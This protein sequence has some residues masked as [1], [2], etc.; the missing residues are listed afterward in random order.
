MADTTM[1]FAFGDAYQA[2]FKE[3]KLSRP[4]TY[5]PEDRDEQFYQRMAEWV[6]G[7]YCTPGNT[8]FR[9]GG[10]LGEGRTIAELRAYARGDQPVD[11]YKKQVDFRSDKGNR[12]ELENISWD[13]TR[14]FN[15]F[16]SIAVAQLNAARYRPG[17][18]AV[19]TAAGEA[20]Q[21]QYQADRLASD[22]RS[23]ALFQQVG[24]MPQGVNPAIAAMDTADVDAFNTLGGYTLFPEVLMTDALQAA[25]DMSGWDNLSEAI[26]EDLFD[27]GVA[28]ALAYRTP[29]SN[30]YL[31]RYTDLAGL[32]LPISTYKDFRD[33]QYRAIVERKSLASLRIESDL[34]EEMMEKIAKSYAG[35][36]NNPQWNNDWSGTNRPGR[37]QFSALRSAR[38]DDF[39]IDVMTLYFVALDAEK[40]VTGTRRDGTAVFDRVRSDAKLGGGD[41]KTGKTFE[42]IPVQ[43]VYRCRWVVGTN[44]VF[45]CGKDDTVVRDGEKGSKEVVLPLMVYALNEPSFVERCIP[46]IDDIEISTRKKRLSM[47]M[48]PPGPGFSID[49]AL[50]EESVTI[51]TDTYNVRDLVGIYFNTGILYHRSMN[52]FQT[53][54]DGGSNRPPITPLGSQKLMELQTFIT[55]LQTNLQI[56]RETLGT[57]EVASGTANTNGLLNGVANQMQQTANAALSPLLSA[58]RDFYLNAEKVLALKYQSGVAFG[59]IDLRFVPG[60]RGIPKFVKL[61]SSL[62][63]VEFYFTVEAMPSRDEQQMM[64]EYLQKLSQ[65]RR[66]GE[67]VF[68]QVMNLILEGDIRKAQFLLSVAAAKADKMAQDNAMQNIQAQGQQNQQ[69]AAAKEQAR[70]QAEQI[71]VQGKMQM[72]ERQSQLNML[73]EEQKAAFRMR[74]LVMQGA[75]EKEM[76]SVEKSPQP[77][78]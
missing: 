27:V 26:N 59:D 55:D 2:K 34:D 40:Y 42:T 31:L 10:Y 28:C 24:M 35:Q 47:A 50:M 1:T 54:K 43:Y 38:Y 39:S 64:I 29:G 57:N 14:V 78:A 37:Q 49:M 70:A 16:R 22:P 56:L 4:E 48:L 61:D 46:V 77:A 41:V 58:S 25:F 15:K 13:N 69:V 17:L 71:V 11:K 3:G 65:E 73:E 68:F 45:D 19:D 51:G 12:R 33:S 53:S 30:K 75:I 7:C 72:A 76:A 9:N 63:D 44:I 52:E 20:R 62:L 5:R 74:E 18:K 36:I 21:K 67:D 8:Y 32:I 23:K 6:Y 60:S 66:V